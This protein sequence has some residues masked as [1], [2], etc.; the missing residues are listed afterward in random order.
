M[1]QQLLQAKVLA[2]VRGG[3]LHALQARGARERREE[4]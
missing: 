3:A 1:T 2:A 4:P